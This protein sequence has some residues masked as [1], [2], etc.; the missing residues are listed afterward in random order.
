MLYFS[1]MTIEGA[2]GQQPILPVIT[3]DTLSK[4]IAS[5]SHDDGYIAESI[6][7]LAAKDPELLET[8]STSAASLGRA[9]GSDIL[10]GGILVWR[11]FNTQNPNLPPSSFNPMTPIPPEP[12]IREAENPLLMAFITETEEMGGEIGSL[13]KMGAMVTYEWKRRALLERPHTA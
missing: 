12:S 10:I 6:K 7:M 3:S 2:E 9:A 5:F 11:M 13:R 8:L 1:T 4:V